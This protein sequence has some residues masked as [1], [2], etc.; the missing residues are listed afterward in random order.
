[1]N[2]LTVLELNHLIDNFSG[3]KQAKYN[4]IIYVK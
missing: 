2:G 4:L 3:K 1:M